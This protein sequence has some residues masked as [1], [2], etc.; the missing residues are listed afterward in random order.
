MLRVKAPTL[1]ATLPRLGRTQSEYSIPERL[2]VTFHS[3]FRVSPIHRIKRSLILKRPD[4][5]KRC[6]T[7]EESNDRARHEALEVVGVQVFLC[8]ADQAADYGCDK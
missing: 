5:S 1:L 2:A 6:K 7:N 8:D 3:I 4:Q